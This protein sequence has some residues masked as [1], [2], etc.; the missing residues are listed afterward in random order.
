MPANLDLDNILHLQKNMVA[1]ASYLPLCRESTLASVVKKTKTKLF[2]QSVRF[3]VSKEQAL[4]RN[5]VL[6][7]RSAWKQ[8]FKAVYKM[9]SNAVV[10]SLLCSKMFSGSWKK[11]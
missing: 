8:Y 1:E 9:T 10:F 11:L 7:T 6:M 4:K 2:V 5:D 3:C